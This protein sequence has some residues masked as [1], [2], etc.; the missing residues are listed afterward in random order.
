MPVPIPYRKFC[1]AGSPVLKPANSPARFSAIATTAAIEAHT[2]YKTEHAISRLRVEGVIALIIFLL[3]CSTPVSP[4]SRL[5]IAAQR[6]VLAAA[7]E[8]KAQKRETAKAQKKL[9]KT[10]TQSAQPSAAPSND[11]VRSFST[12]ETIQQK[13]TS[14]Q[15]VHKPNKA[16][17]TRSQA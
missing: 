6:L 5:L 2:T 16:M 3:Y 12:K 9:Q 1:S 11:G 10:R 13:Y 7:G 4:E 17:E 15:Q 8:K 14:N